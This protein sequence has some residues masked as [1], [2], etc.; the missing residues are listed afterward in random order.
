MHLK[1][2]LETRKNFNNYYH[3]LYS[4]SMLSLA[5]ILQLI[6]ESSTTYRLVGLYLLAD[7]WLICRLRVQCMISFWDECQMGSVW[8]CIVVIYFKT[9]YNKTIII[10]FGFCDTQNNQGLDE[11]YQS[12]PSARLITLTST[13]N[14]L[15]RISQKPHPIQL[16]FIIIYCKPE[17]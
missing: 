11:C 13:F 8:R 15:F 17:H 4:L 6:L 12:R 16:L 14:W 9:M 2:D 10:R 3:T 1:D 5:K 7:N